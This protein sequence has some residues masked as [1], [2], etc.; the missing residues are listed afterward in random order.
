V[1]DGLKKRIKQTVDFDD[2]VG[3]AFLNVIVAADVIRNQTSAMMAKYNLTS[4]QYNVLRILRGVYPE[5]HSRCDIA[6]RM[7]ENAPDVT[8]LVDRLENAGLVTRDRSDEDRRRS[9]TKITEKG[10]ALMKEMDTDI[11]P[12]NMPL[13]YRLTHEEARQ[14]IELCEKIYA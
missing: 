7:V 5:G 9:V 10:L 6:Q 4:G 1:S 11:K 8:R 13:Y 3:E 12:E 2:P 14:L